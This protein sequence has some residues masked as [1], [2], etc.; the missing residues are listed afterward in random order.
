MFA[1]PLVKTALKQD[2]SQVSATSRHVSSVMFHVLWS[3]NPGGNRR[4]FPTAFCV[5]SARNICQLELPVG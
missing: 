5:S 2:S 4:L 1:D 3:V